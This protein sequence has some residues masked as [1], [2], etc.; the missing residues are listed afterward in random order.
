MFTSG[1]VSSKD[2]LAGSDNLLSYITE[3][4][5]L[6]R[7]E[8]RVCVRHPDS[9]EEKE[10]ESNQTFSLQ[11]R[12][13]MQLSKREKFNLVEKFFLHVLLSVLLIAV[14]FL[15]CVCVQEVVKDDLGFSVRLH[16]FFRF[17]VCPLRDQISWY[18]NLCVCS[19]CSS[20]SRWDLLLHTIPQAQY[21]AA[22]GIQCQRA[23]HTL[24]LPH[25]P[26]IRP[27]PPDKHAGDFFHLLTSYP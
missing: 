12:T 21:T 7:S 3:L 27:P 23:L 15:L 13:E 10:E 17:P 24:P 16:V 4:L 6:L 11:M 14:I 20:S 8:E 22:Q 2:S 19:C 26:R 5:L 18:P 1:L 25:P 9:G